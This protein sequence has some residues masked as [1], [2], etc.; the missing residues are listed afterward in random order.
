M[1]GHGA[2]SKI[3]FHWARILLATACPGSPA[4]WGGAPQYFTRKAMTGGFVRF[5]LDEYNL[6][7]E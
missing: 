5:N 6:D 7:F 1:R 4:L 2:Q 3:R